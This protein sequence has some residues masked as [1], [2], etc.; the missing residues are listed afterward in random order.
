MCVCVC[1]CLCV[2]NCVCVF[3]CV[4]VYVC[5]CVCTCRESYLSIIGHHP[6]SDALARKLYNCGSGRDLLSLVHIHLT[7]R[8]KFGVA[9][10]FGSGV[11]IKTLKQL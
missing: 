2:C 9:L 6:Y 7:V 11:I 5:V 4:C 8:C 3:E 1:V 10:L